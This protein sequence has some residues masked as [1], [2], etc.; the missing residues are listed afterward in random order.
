MLSD[1]SFLHF[2]SINPI[3]DVWFASILSHPVDSL[4]SLL[5]VGSEAQWYLPY[6]L[7]VITQYDLVIFLPMF[8]ALA[9]GNSV[10][11]LGLLCLFFQFY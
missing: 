9:P 10:R 3:S 8:P 7:V 2:L 5:M 11:W 1:N 4:F 6:T